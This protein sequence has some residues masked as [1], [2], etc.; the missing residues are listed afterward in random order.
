MRVYQHQYLTMHGASYSFVRIFYLRG[1]YRVSSIFWMGCIFHVPRWI[2]AF[3]SAG[4]LQ[5]NKFMNFCHWM[6]DMGSL[7]IGIMML[8]QFIC[9]SLKNRGSFGHIFHVYFFL[10]RRL[11][12]QYHFR[13]RFKYANTSL[14]V[15]KDSNIVQNFANTKWTNML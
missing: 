14:D 5:N 1:Q 4:I 10:S 6:M 9:L 2:R 12:P 7:R 15:L 8:H 11:L 13:N 3:Y